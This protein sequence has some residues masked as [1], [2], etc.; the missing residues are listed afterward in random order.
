MV[1]GRRRCRALAAVLAALGA[2]AVAGCSSAPK[3]AIA[4]PTAAERQAA[5]AAGFELPPVRKA[6]ELLPPELLQGPHYTLGEKVYTDGYTHVFTIVSDFGVL[7]AR[8]DDMLGVR[9]REVQAIA[10]MREMSATNEFATAA[11]KALASPFVATWNVISHPVDTIVGIPKSAWQTVRRTSD[12]AS[13]DRGELEDSAMAEFIGFEAKKRQITGELGVD[14]Y[15]SNRLLQKELNR[16]AWAAYAGGLPSMF[17][18]FS[19]VR[20]AEED[21]PEA[22]ISESRLQKILREYSPEDLD[23]LNR[24]ELAVM[25]VPK[26]LSEKF[27]EH[28]WYSPRYETTLVEH[29]SAL[30]LAQDRRAFIEIALTADSESDAHFYQRSAEL[31]RRYNDDVGHIDKI[32]N[33][34]GT[35][36]GYAADGTLVVPFAADHAVWSASTATFA[37]SF[38]QAVPE[39]VEVRRTELLLSGTLSPKARAN[40][41]SRG[42]E[43]TDRAF[44]RLRSRAAE[45]SEDDG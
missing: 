31:M 3:P 30:D 7:H 33:V 11:G 26:P 42:V 25:G 32:I 37:D 45:S 19:E 20:S 5:A 2:L 9:L 34:A 12:I 1:S 21:D 13:S 22:A 27:I 16:F 36:T 14:P 23:R 44:D 40:F 28:P 39:D 29:L 17:V 6:S 41:E 10:A 38:T 15:S 24:I 43:V 4:I 35:V 18:P 8:G